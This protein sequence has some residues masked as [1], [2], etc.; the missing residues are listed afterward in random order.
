MRTPP[1]PHDDAPT[2]VGSDAG[3][4]GLARS[5]HI[6]NAARNT[7]GWWTGFRPSTIPAMER[8]NYRRELFAGLFL[9]FALTAFEGAVISVIARLTF[10]GH[11][12]EGPLEYAAG[13]LAV[14]PALA[15]ITSFAWV[16]LAHG[17]DKVR[18]INA[19]QILV[20][21]I[22]ALMA[23]VPQTA[24]GLWL[25]TAQV[26]IARVCW[27]GI[28]TL[29]STVWRQ[30]YPKSRRAQITGRFAAVQVLLIALLGWGLGLAMDYND[31]A[32]RILY[33]AAA[34]LGIFGVLHWRRVR[35]RQHGNLINE[36]RRTPPKESPSFNP[37]ALV[38]VLVGDRR[39][40]AFMA[41]QF[42]LGMGNITAMAILP[43]VLAD[44]FTLSYEAS[45]LITS[46]ISLVLMP[47][48]IPLWARLLDGTHIVHFRAIHSWVFV[49][50]LLSLAF[51]AWHGIVWLMFA[52][53][54][55]R[56]IAFGGGVLAWTLGHL[57]FAPPDKASQYMGVH[58][59]LTGVRGLLSWLLGVASYRALETLDPGH[60]GAW[61]F[62]LCGALAAIGAI[63]FLAMSI[64]FK[65][66]HV[67]ARHT[68]VTETTP[69]SRVGV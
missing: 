30:N 1:T 2:P 43:L 14:I 60:G 29:R 51:G 32:F 20:L 56:G 9:P 23:L 21:I 59:T 63:G 10:D 69:P 4:P 50:A 31:Q 17:A 67:A 11:V 24:L 27:A 55:F 18:F 52:A 44:R 8:H 19:L 15:N 28:I 68:K 22:V 58:V 48:V 62:I 12:A 65:R 66:E 38:A 53:A 35:V 7:V 26:L 45:L 13:L 6:R 36:E 25:L 57:D 42:A 33:P 61:M 34:V 16:R 3:A 37:L 49:A 5:R 47:L 40:A 46:S 39:Y 54:V 64:W 41:C